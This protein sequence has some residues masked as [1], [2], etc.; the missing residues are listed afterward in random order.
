MASELKDVLDIPSRIIGEVSKVVIGKG[1]L[2]EL[3]LAALLS[4][5]H[6]LIEGLPGTA[7]TTLA[8]TFAV[9]IGGQF[10]RIQL[11]PDML[12]A[13]ITGFYL[14]S[15]D[16]G[17][18]FRPGPLFANIVLA[19][20]LNRTTPRTQSAL[21]EAMQESQVTIEGQTHPL[22]RPFMVVASQLAYGA[23]G[24]Y[25]L[26]EVSIDRFMFRIWCGLPSQEEEKQVIREIDRLDHPDIKAVVTS[27]ELLRVQEA[28]KQVHVS[29]KVMDYIIGLV[30]KVR[31]SPDVLAGPSPRGGIAL[32][33]GARALALLR[34]RDFV[35]PDD[36]KWLL[37]PALTHRTR[38]KPEA[39]ME[40]V[41]AGSIIEAA[42]TEVPVPKME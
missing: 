39:E 22:P 36:I 21:L 11:T 7:K 37:I 2:K 9:A 23:E 15:A 30:D 40:G 42:A 16:G 12:P 26:T 29:E 13:D 6:V 24:T 41:T 32:Y 31:Q 5:G 17:S 27:E 14:Y 35:L 25:P 20:E 18:R 10:K 33:K 8:R 3:L 1:E 4:T 38:V 28:V 34:G 19:D